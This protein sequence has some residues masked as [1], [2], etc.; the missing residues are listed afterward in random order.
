[1]K[2]VIFVLVIL[3]LLATYAPDIF[4]LAILVLV[5]LAILLWMLKLKAI[6]TSSLS[7][8]EMGE[9]IVSLEAESLLDENKY[10]LLN[11]LN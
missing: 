8:G 1:M 10:H 3:F 4:P 7:K 2:R 6:P 9:R 11:Y 5:P